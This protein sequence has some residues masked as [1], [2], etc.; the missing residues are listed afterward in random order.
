MGL[1]QMLRPKPQTFKDW[2]AK[3]V[4]ISLFPPSNYKVYIIQTK[5]MQS[6]FNAF[7]EECIFMGGGDF[8]L[9]IS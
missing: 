9:C 8:C 6:T 3:Y 2:F 1:V 7:H 5:Q 4:H